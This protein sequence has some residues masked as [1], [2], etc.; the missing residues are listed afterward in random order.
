MDDGVSQKICIYCNKKKYNSEFSLEHIWPDAL[1]GDLLGNFWKTNLVCKTCNNM[2]GVFVDGAFIKS[3]II[4]HERGSDALDYLAGSQSTGTIP[5]SYLGFIQNIQVAKDEVIDFWVCTG[6]NVLH[7]RPKGEEIWSS[8]AG[9]DPRNA[10][11]GSKAGRVIIS[12]TS[13]EYFWVCTALRSVKQHFPKAVQFVT[14]IDLPQ[15]TT[16]FRYLNPNDT[17][18][19]DD[20]RIFREFN[21]LCK[22]GD[23]IHSQFSINTHSDGRFLSKLALGIGH[24][25]FG[26]KFINESYANTLR[27]SFREADAEKRY[28]L[29]VRGTGYFNGLDISGFSD[30]LR[31]PGGWQITLRLLEKK[32]VLIVMTPTGEMMAIQITDNPMLVDRLDS[33]YFEGFSWVVVPA[34]Q[35]AVGPLSYPEYVAHMIGAESNAEL[36]GLEC[37]R[38]DSS[39]LP[40]TGIQSA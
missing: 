6:A 7:I 35:K 27:A 11:K 21:T 33:N 17:Q 13:A 18:Q 4:S 32:L 3:L 23:H 1:G 12:L 8:Y 24:N 10:S 37:L 19:A 15:N 31:W 20:L 40:P 29:N 9:G 28:K 36:N 38:G 22:N 16:G 34:V 25:I 26:R 14:N 5:L 39:K 30:V 2:S